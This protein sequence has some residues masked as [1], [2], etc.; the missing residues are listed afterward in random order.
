MPTTVF[1]NSKGEI[2]KKWSG[3]LNGDVLAKVT[4]EMLDQESAG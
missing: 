4:E 3:A 2:F 1:I